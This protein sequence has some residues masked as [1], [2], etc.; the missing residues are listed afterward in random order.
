MAVFDSIEGLLQPTSPALVAGPD[1]PGQVRA[2]ARSGG[3]IASVFTWTPRPGQDPGVTSS[4]CAVAGV[5]VRESMLPLWVLDPERHPEVEALLR[6]CRRSPLAEPEP[7]AP[8]GGPGVAAGRYR[9]GGRPPP[10]SGERCKRGTRPARRRPARRAASRRGEAC[11][12]WSAGCVAGGA[13]S[14]GESRRGGGH[15]PTIPAAV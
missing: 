13:P 4:A 6:S 3:V 1:E 11:G 7:R 8:T 10:P 2:E 9:S 5:Q 14:L 15:L 12:S